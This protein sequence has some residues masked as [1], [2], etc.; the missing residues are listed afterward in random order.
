MGH[1]QARTMKRLVV[2]VCSLNGAWVTKQLDEFVPGLLDHL[3]IPQVGGPVSEATPCLTQG[4][5]ARSHH[6]CNFSVKG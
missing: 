4:L 5:P 3:Q 6:D 1:M 2:Q